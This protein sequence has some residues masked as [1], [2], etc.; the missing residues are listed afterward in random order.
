V[1]LAAVQAIRETLD[2]NRDALQKIAGAP[3]SELDRL[4]PLTEHAHADL[5]KQGKSEAQRR[6]AA[7]Y[8]RM[9]DQVRLYR[10]YMRS[11][12]SLLRDWEKAPSDQLIPPHA[13][14]ELNSIYQ[15]QNYIVGPAPGGLVLDQ[16]GSLDWQ[17]SF[18]RVNYFT[19]LTGVR[20]R[21]VPQPA[22]GS[23]PV[24]FVAARVPQQALVKSLPP[25]LA[26][27]T[28]G[29]WVYKDAHNQALILSRGDQL[30]YLP[31][32]ELEETAQG[33]LHFS[34]E[35]WRPGLP[36]A[37]LED[38][39]FTGSKEWLDQ[40]HSQRDWL[41]AT[42][43]TVY[44]NAVDG[45]FVEL[46]RLTPIEDPSHLSGNNRLVREFQWRERQSVQADLLLMANNH[47][48]FNVRSFNPGGNHGSFFRVSTHSSLL[49][50]GG[51]KT[52]L[53][54]GLKITEPYDGL[55]YV[56]TMLKLVGMPGYRQ[57]P[58]PVIEELFPAAAVTTQSQPPGVTGQ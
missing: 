26:P 11:V 3:A 45:L 33:E 56:P 44:S 30:R 15:L 47:W 53:P 10:E 8:L 17:N 39:G 5:L 36:F 28:D 16:S 35:P 4:Q 2:R 37:L 41:R 1:R 42:H 48:N 32:K 22:L 52:G 57:L 21:N 38:P 12:S 24:D 14:G 6:Q 25:D 31:V 9:A 27:D 55:S 49:F 13:M 58:G 20:M 54:R 18:R 50:A 46:S 7:L 51:A 23:Q 43:Q 19:F 40:W 29:V 34:I